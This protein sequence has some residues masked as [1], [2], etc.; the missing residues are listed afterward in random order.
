MTDK[1]I[2]FN[3][4]NCEIG[5]T[6]EYTIFSSADP[7]TKIIGTKTVLNTIESFTDIMLPGIA[8]GTITVST[9][10]K[11]ISNNVSTAGT[12]TSVYP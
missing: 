10:L 5:T 3:V 7:N 11:D 12:G 1:K 6:L 4:G 8:D 2:Q 9:T